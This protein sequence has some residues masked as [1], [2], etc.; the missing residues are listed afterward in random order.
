[1]ARHH[2]LIVPSIPKLMY[3]IK[4]IKYN[5][6]VKMPRHGFSHIMMGD[7]TFH[8]YVGRWRLKPNSIFGDDDFSYLSNQIL[9]ILPLDNLFVSIMTMEK[10]DHSYFSYV[11]SK[12]F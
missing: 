2:I 10:G 8:K 6:Q 12:L 3:Y 4:K 11:Y 7:S 5:F 9:S 1:M